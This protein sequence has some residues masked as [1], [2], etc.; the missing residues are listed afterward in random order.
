[1]ETDQ[2][3]KSEAG[4]KAF[5]APSYDMWLD[6]NKRH[7]HK[8]WYLTIFLAFI[9]IWK[10]RV[11]RSL[12]YKLFMENWCKL[13]CFKNWLAHWFTIIKV[14]MEIE[15]SKHKKINNYFPFL[16]KIW[17]NCYWTFLSNQMS[18]QF[19]VLPITSDGL[20]WFLWH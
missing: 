7:A 9:G 1:M 16:K 17:E 12:F 4:P 20:I 5:K 2:L 3:K 6:K 11:R 14:Q 18:Y 15:R 10:K 8:Q 19:R 13:Q